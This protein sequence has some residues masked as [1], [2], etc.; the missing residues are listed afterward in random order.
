MFK[1]WSFLIKRLIKCLGVFLQLHSCTCQYFRKTLY[2][3]SHCETITV[4]P[5]TNYIVI[6]TS[7]QRFNKNNIYLYC[8]IL[9]LTDTLDNYGIGTEIF[10]NHFCLMW[11][12]TYNHWPI[13][14]NFRSY[15][16]RFFIKPRHSILKTI[17]YEPL[18]WQ[19]YHVREEALF[20]SNFC[21]TAIKTAFIFPWQTRALSEALWK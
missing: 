18:L 3:K 12:V 13:M 4:L 9:S 1:H 5:P 2:R 19:I 8:N 14:V 6:E 7:L 10:S 17:T 21:N 20:C 16:A 11:L 15:R